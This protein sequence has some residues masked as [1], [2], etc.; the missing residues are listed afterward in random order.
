M[1]ACYGRIGLKG[2]PGAHAPILLH[3]SP[4][5][6]IV[7]LRGVWAISML[8]SCTQNRV[9]RR[10]MNEIWAPI[11]ANTKQAVNYSESLWSSNTQ[12]K[13]VDT[14][15]ENEVMQHLLLPLPWATGFKGNF[16]PLGEG[17][18]E[19]WLLWQTGALPCT[20]LLSSDEDFLWLF[21][22]PC[23]PWLGSTR[24]IKLVRKEGWSW[25]YSLDLRPLQTSIP[26]WVDTKAWI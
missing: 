25:D 1:V 3:P 9:G 23:Y 10:E 12:L 14:M 8:I 20:F 19:C 4:A 16:L 7:W 18:G 15:R 11:V 21:L 5:A 6:E 17:W 2:S 26:I 24:V 22:S 13:G